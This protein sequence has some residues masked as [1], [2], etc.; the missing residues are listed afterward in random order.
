M[1]FRKILFFIP[2]FILNLQPLYS[3]GSTGAPILK[4]CPSPRVNALGESGVSF[5]G[6]YTATGLNPAQL[7]TLKKNA[8]SA[9]FYEAFLDSVVG[10]A[11]GALNVGPGSIAIDTLGYVG[12]KITIDDTAG[13]Y[14]DL[15]EESF[16]T[17]EDMVYSAGYGAKISPKM[18]GGLKVRYYTSTLLETY[19]TAALSIDGGFLWDTPFFKTGNK[20]V[21]GRIFSPG[22]RAGMSVLN[23][24]KG[25]GYTKEGA[26]DPL[27]T[28]IK[29]GVSY[30]AI[31]NEEHASLISLDSTYNFGSEII[32]INTGFEYIYRD[33]FFLRSGYRFNYEI[34]NFT[35]GAGVKYSRF[36][37]DYGMGIAQAMNSEHTLMFTVNF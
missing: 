25:V 21:Y 26:T 15:H 1:F 23:M 10:Y 28:L 29:G 7:G 12:G 8:V 9:V 31:F 22:I 2:V 37:F 33:M 16:I 4:F 14:E 32:R 6:D 20:N 13:R 30:P 3:N 17:Q 11:G 34:K 27:P 5:M 36:K 18:Y 24:G 35:W 19:E